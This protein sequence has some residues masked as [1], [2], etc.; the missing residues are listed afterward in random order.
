MFDG[1]PVLQHIPKLPLPIQEFT[2]AAGQH[3]ITGRVAW[4]RGGHY[5]IYDQGQW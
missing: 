4:L 3:A 1:S 2:V 5:G